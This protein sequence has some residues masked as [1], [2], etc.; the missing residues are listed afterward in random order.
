MRRIDVQRVLAALRLQERACAS[1][2]LPVNQ[3][4]YR[5]ASRDDSRGRLKHGGALRAQA[6]INVNKHELE[7]YMVKIQTCGK[8]RR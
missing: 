1:E 7:R 5:R 4:T 2:P 6:I 3:N 8:D